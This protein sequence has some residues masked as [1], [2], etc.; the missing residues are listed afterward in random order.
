MAMKLFHGMVFVVCSRCGFKNSQDNGKSCV[1]CG[2]DLNPVA[3]QSNRVWEICRRLKRY[4][5]SLVL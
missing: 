2:K 1:S 4:G 3:R 5:I